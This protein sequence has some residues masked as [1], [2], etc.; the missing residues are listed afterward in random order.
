MEY[1]IERF[2]EN[3]FAYPFKLSQKFDK[4][5]LKDEY[6]NFQDKCKHVLNYSVSLKPNLLSTFFDKLAFDQNVIEAV[7]KIIGDD[8]YIWSSAFFPKEPGKA[9]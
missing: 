9:K 5:Q 2:N 6:Y 7:K 8:I 1:D 3:G 4:K